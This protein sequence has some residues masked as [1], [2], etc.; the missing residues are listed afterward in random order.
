MSEV[1]V[2][3]VMEKAYRFED[4]PNHT[5]DVEARVHVVDQTATIKSSH[6]ARDNLIHQLLESRKQCPEVNTKICYDPTT[7]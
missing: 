6:E 5:Q 3:K 2:D 4:F 7:K 1:E